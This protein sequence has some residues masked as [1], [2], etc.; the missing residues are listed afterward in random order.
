MDLH[1]YDI[2]CHDTTRHDSNLSKKV[3]KMG[4]I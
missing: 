1:P 4:L 3:G 2:V